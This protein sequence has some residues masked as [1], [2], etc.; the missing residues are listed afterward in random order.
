[1]R[2][3]VI[4]A[5]AGLSLLMYA[6]DG[7][8]VAVA[9]P[10]FM[11][12]FSTNVLW[13]G[14]TISIYLVAIT[15]IMPLAGKLSDS[16]GSKKVFLVSLILFTGGSL[17][18]GFAPNIYTLIVFR[19][20]QGVGGASFIPTATAIVSDQFPESRQSVVGLTASI[21]PI[22]GIVGPNLGGWMIS[23][24]SWR[25]IFYINLP[26]GILLIGLILV[27]LKDSKV[28]SRPHIDFAG[29]SFFFG[30]IL[31]LMIGLNL[32][33][34]KFSVGL[35]FLTA[36]SWGI[37][38]GFAFLFLRHEKKDPSPILDI[39]LLKSRPFMAANL[40]N[41]V[42]GIAV[43]GIF[44]I[45][46]YYATSR[47]RLSTLV[48]GMILT[49]CAIG[50]ICTAIIVSFQLRRWGYRWPMVLGLVITSLT[51]FLLDQGFHLFRVIG[52]PFGIVETIIFIVMLSGIGMGFIF[53]ASNNACI[54]LMPDKVATITGLRGMFRSIG[55]ALGISLITVIL[56]LSSTP[57]QGFKTVF[58]SFGLGLL[59][60]IP[61]VFLMP[62][63]RKGW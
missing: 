58:L 46:P 15:S 57:D 51:T 8:A 38:I 50:N 30:G 11:K 31:F 4:F 40:Y 27:L 56:H 55:G 36:L 17:A 49:P 19:L 21:F 61:L 3:Y 62:T 44:N 29:A 5:S 59:F 39:A 7:S 63:G 22:G 48:S 25:Y 9:F 35:L 33:G 43:F 6:I 23:R 28:L 1:M 34:E 32:I 53:P 41:T 26:I 45:I 2:R 10:N 60:T 16:F 37:S 12:E 14:W 20:L 47:L 13:A 54:E 24:Y 42:V 18:C 52:I